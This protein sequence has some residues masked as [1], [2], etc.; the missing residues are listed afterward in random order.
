MVADV[1]EDRRDRLPI[2]KRA[3]PGGKMTSNKKV[4]LAAFQKRLERRV[5][6]LSAV[7]SVAKGQPEPR[8]V[9][10]SDD[11]E[12]EKEETREEHAAACKKFG[13]SKNGN[14]EET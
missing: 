6:P 13:G 8:S 4:A 12:E 1:P 5:V 11:E 3:W 9:Q 10:G 14:S 7:T 2:G